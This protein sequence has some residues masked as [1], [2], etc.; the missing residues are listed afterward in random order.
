MKSK[1]KVTFCCL[2]LIAILTWVLL[3]I[4]YPIIV[5]DGELY[6]Q[7]KIL[8]VQRQYASFYTPRLGTFT[9][10][11]KGHIESRFLAYQSSI[12]EMASPAENEGALSGIIR[13]FYGDIYAAE[14]RLMER[15][16]DLLQN[17]K[18]KF[19]LPFQTRAITHKE[20][21]LES[22][23]SANPENYSPCMVF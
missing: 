11:V 17:E 20:D 5:I 1:L 14:T 22:F 6:S 18:L 23:F 16:E 2:G 15:V 10:E 4:F 12:N 8:Q 9:E 21:L 19:S 3:A 7:R 13:E